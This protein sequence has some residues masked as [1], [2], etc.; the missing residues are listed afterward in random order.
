MREAAQA[1]EVKQE[2]LAKKRE[3]LEEAV[4]RK[5]AKG[6][7][8]Y[9]PAGLYLRKMRKGARILKGLRFKEVRGGPRVAIINAAGG[10]NSGKSGSSPV[11]G[12]TLGSD[13]LIELIRRAKADPGT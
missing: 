11:Q 10:I 7:P 4:E 9:F 3:A 12:K 5:I 8:S 2:K 6:E 13:T 1:D